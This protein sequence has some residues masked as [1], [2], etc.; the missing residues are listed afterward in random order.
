MIAHAQDG[1]SFN[2]ADFATPPDGRSG[3]M[4]MF[5]WNIVKPVRDGDFDNAIITH[6]FAHG[7]TN[8]MTGGPAN[9]NCLSYG[10]A[11]GMGEGWGDVRL[12]YTKYPFELTTPF[13]RHLHYSL[14]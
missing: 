2:N 11:R 4:R 8:R 13:C 3:R 5:L 1:S 14:A 10:L 6:E 12:V 9:A 7:V